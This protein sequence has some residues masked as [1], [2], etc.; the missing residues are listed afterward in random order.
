MRQLSLVL[1]PLRPDASDWWP[2]AECAA[3]AVLAA[4]ITMLLKG[5]T[6]GHIETRPNVTKEI[7][8]QRAAKYHRDVARDVSLDLAESL[9]SSRVTQHCASPTCDSPLR[10]PCAEFAMYPSLPKFSST[11]ARPL[12]NE[13]PVRCLRTWKTASCST[14]PTA[15]TGPTAAGS[16]TV[17][18]TAPAWRDTSV[19]FQTLNAKFAQANWQLQFQ[20]AAAVW[21]AVANINLR[22]SPTT[23]VQRAQR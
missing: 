21:Q 22:R 20:K 23:E 10:M 4:A 3:R 12:G 5:I 19:L 17:S 7:R 1:Q 18:P 13:R 16:P 2:I 6:D 14:A 8:D 15:V 11:A 9:K